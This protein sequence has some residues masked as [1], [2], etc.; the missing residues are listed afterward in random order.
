[1]PGRRIGKLVAGGNS[2]SKEMAVYG[3]V[4]TSG[5]SR[6]CSCGR[7]IA[8][9]GG[10]QAGKHAHIALRSLHA[11]HCMHCIGCT[12][13]TARI[14]LRCLCR[15]HCPPGRAAAYLTCA[16]ANGRRPRGRCWQ[17]IGWQEPGAAQKQRSRA[18]PAQKLP[19]EIRGAGDG[20]GAGTGG[21][22]R[23]QQQQAETERQTDREGLDAKAAREEE[24]N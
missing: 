18:L 12:A 1:M 5:V 9:L 13:C 7:G 4:V 22:R 20:D 21:E 3:S 14:A 23:R 17:P 19:A 15:T 2:L 8:A 10:W 16:A 11:L 6:P 24:K